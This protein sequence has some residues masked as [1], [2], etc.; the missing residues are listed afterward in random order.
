MIVSS[1]IA[2]KYFF[3]GKKSFINVISIISMLTLAI[4]TCALFIV[5]SVFN[6]LSF[7]ISDVHKSFDAEVRIETLHGKVLENIDSLL[8][9]LQQNPNIK[10][11]TQVIEDDAFIN[12]QNNQRVVRVKG[13]SD[14]YTEQ[15]RLE[16]FIHKGS[17]TLTDSLRHYAVVGR[18]IEYDLNISTE[19][20][21]HPL[22]IWYPKRKNK[23]F[24]DENALNSIHVF[25]GGVFEIERQYDDVYLFISL[26]RAKYL[27]SYT[28]ELTAIELKLKD[29][30]AK[31]KDKIISKL[32]AKYDSKYKVLS[33]AEQH[34]TLYKAIRLERLIAVFIFV[35]ILSIAVINIYL[36]LTM[37]VVSKQHDIS[38]LS[39]LGADRFM[40]FSIFLTE[41]FIIGA[42]GSVLGLAAG[43]GICWL[44]QEFGFYKM[45]I[46]SSITDAFPVK[47]QR[48]DAYLTLAITFGI[49]ILISIPPAFKASRIE[50]KNR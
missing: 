27:F 26:E 21:Y 36:T 22:E 3:S 48:M 11:V 23:N 33:S 9:E 46:E 10:V 12:Y 4:G 35:F 45:A 40:V 16:A 17:S 41:G 44:Q 31:E 49:T 20:F 8:I 37:I 15:N 5:L 14:N 39:A 30:T 25:P 42:I 29:G 19:D 38:I 47:M 28:N 6:G 32:K 13:V 1:Q 18:G 50:L 7:L 34:A 2:W 24:K 43:L